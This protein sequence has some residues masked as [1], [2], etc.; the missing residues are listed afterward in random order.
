LVLFWENLFF[1]IIYF[2]SAPGVITKKP[3]N[4]GKYSAGIINLLKPTAML[5]SY[6]FVYVTLYRW[7]FKNFG[8]GRLPAF[9]SL[10]NVSFLLIVLLTNAMLATELMVKLHWI[11][12]NS[13]FASLVLLGAVFFMLLNHLI[14]L[15]NRWVKRLNYNLATI[16]K[17]NLNRWSVVLLVN[18]IITCGF[19]ISMV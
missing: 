17:H 4:P 16:S 9:K 7:S 8:P 13:Y 6:Q 14:L 5:K 15:N 10:F 3:V 1:K 19:F 12:P 11:T 2:V 18:V